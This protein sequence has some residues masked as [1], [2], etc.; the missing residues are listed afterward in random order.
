MKINDCQIMNLLNKDQ[1]TTLLTHFLETSELGLKNGK[2]PSE[3]PQP[4]GQ[5]GGG[6]KNGRQPQQTGGLAGK[7][8]QPD[9]F[10]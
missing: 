9:R 1:L 5:A 2:Q 7:G 10:N 4:G 3:A 6:L 8:G